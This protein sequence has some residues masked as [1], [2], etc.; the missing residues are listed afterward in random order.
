MGVVGA[1]I[2]PH[3]FYLHSALVLNRDLDENDRTDDNIKQ[4]CE[5]NYIESALSLFI[6]FIINVGII[7]LFG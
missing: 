5:F 4:I 2:M 1:V 3:N 6:S 7:S